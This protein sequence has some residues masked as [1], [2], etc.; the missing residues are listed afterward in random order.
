M[1]TTPYVPRTFPSSGWRGRT[2][3]VTDFRH[4]G[5]RCREHTGLPDT[6]GNRRRLERVL[7]RIDAEQLL[8]NFDYARHFPNG[9]Q[10]ERFREHAR[11]REEAEA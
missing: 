11:R 2:S 7:Q 4:A 9:S 6:P 5:V 3:L 1:E 8:G 10:I